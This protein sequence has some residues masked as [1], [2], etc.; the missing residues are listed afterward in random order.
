MLDCAGTAYDSIRQA[1]LSGRFER[2]AR[3][4]ERNLSWELGGTALHAIQNQ[5]T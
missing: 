3:L 2:G 1:I 4:S 5:S